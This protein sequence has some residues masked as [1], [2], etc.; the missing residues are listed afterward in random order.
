MTTPTYEEHLRRSLLTADPYEAA[1]IERELKVMAL[2][3]A[4][5]DDGLNAK[6]DDVKEGLQI[7]AEDNIDWLP[8]YFA[9]HVNMDEIDIERMNEAVIRFSEE[10]DSFL[11]Q[12]GQL[13]DEWQACVDTAELKDSKAGSDVESETEVVA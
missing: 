7:L 13:M 3:R 9:D 1:A 6:M 4:L 10:T 8:E 5:D 12:W 2:D 11:E